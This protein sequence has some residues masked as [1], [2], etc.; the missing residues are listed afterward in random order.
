[1]LCLG[2]FQE[3]S[4]PLKIEICQENTLD[5]VPERQCSPD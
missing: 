5:L 3:P 2:C 4:Q 1:M